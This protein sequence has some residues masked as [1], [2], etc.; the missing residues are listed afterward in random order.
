[1][2]EDEILFAGLDDKIRFCEYN[3]MITN[4]NFLDIYRQ[5]AALNYLR[6]KKVRFELYGGFDDAERKMFVFLPDYI[7]DFGRLDRKSTRSHPIAALN[8]RK[9]SFSELSHRDYL[10]AILGLGVKREMIGDLV[11]DSGGCT[12]AA[13]KS[14]AGYISENLCSVGRGSV[15]VTV[16]DSFP[17]SE[18]D[19]NYELMRCY[20][21]SMRADSVAAS[22]FS[23]SRSSA[24]ELITRGELIVNGIA[25]SKP[26]MKIDFG[27]KLV[28]RGKGKAVITS[29]EG[30]TKKGRQAFLVKRY[31]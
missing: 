27:S 3:Y 2:T 14:V 15:R 4:T 24:N 9:D 18:T 28:I 25:A 12:V 10:G 17:K 11:L 23:I 21:S 7:E 31:K 29:D 22:A 16:E 5:S 30:I 8:I 26:D 13:L 19:S 1:M 6:N 20:V